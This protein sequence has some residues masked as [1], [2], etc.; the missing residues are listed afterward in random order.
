MLRLPLILWILF[1]GLSFYSTAQTYDFQRITQE[2]GLPSS[3]ITCMTQDSRNLLWIG[4]DG[5]GLVRFD[6]M[7]YTTFDEPNLFDNRFI[8]DIKEDS[9][10]NLVLCTRYN[11]VS[12][13]DGNRFFKSF[14]PRNSALRSESIW[15]SIPDEGGSYFFGD[16]EIF[17]IDL[18][19]KLTVLARNK[20]GYGVI[21]SVVKCAH[22]KFIFT[23][24][25]G[26]FEL[27]D[28]KVKPLS[29]FDNSYHTLIRKETNAILVGNDAGLVWLYN[30]RSNTKQ[31][32]IQIGTDQPFHI[33][34]M[35]LSRSGNLWLSGKDR[36][37]LL[38]WNDGTQTRFNASNGFTG[39]NVT[40]FYQDEVR[41]LYLGSLGTG[42]FRTGPQ[43]FFNYNNVQGLE[44]PNIFGV[45]STENAVYVGYNQDDAR[46]FTIESNGQ[47]LL[48]RV[49]EGNK[50]TNYFF[51][52]RSKN[53][54]FCS[55]QGVF[56]ETSAGLQ[57][58]TSLKN[59]HVVQA[60]ETDA[61][62]L[63]GTYGKGLLITDK[64]FNIIDIL[65]SNKNPYLPDYVYS[66]HQINA[67]NF[68]ISSNGSLIRISLKNG[69][70][71]FT[72]KLIDDV[73]SI[74]TEDSYGN[75]WY[76]GTNTLYSVSKKGKV[77]KFTKEQHGITSLLAYT[78]IGDNQGNIW[79]GSNRGV[80]KIQVRPNGTILTIKNYNS[81]N[82]FHGLETNIRAQYKDYEGNIY[83][84]TANGLVKC[85][86]AYNAPSWV[87]P[88]IVIS[89]VSVLN[90]TINWKPLN[91]E[92][93]WFN[94][95]KSKHIFK[96]TENQLTFEFTTVNAG[97]TDQFYYSYKL[98]GLDKN[99][100]EPST[101]QTVTYSNLRPGSYRFIVR[102]VDKN[103]V[104]FKTS[105]PLPF[106]ID[107]PFYASW[108]FISLT[109]VIAALLIYILIRQSITYNKEFVKESASSRD[110]KI[111]QLRIYLL[112]LGIL[113]P[114]SELVIEL[115]SIRTSSELLINLILGFMSLF[116][117]V[118][119]RKRNIF[120]RYL[121][122]MI[123]SVYLLYL[124]ISWYK[125]IALPFEFITIA[126]YFF[127]VFLGHIL[128]LNAKHYFVFLG[129]LALFLISI[130]FTPHLEV[131][132]SIIVTYI[133][134]FI[135]IIV[136]IKN[137]INNNLRERVILA[138][139]IVNNGQSI[140]ITANKAGEISFVSENVKELLGYS[141]H[142]LLGNQWWEKTIDDKVEFEN[143]KQELIEKLK[144]QEIT[145]RLVKTKSGA[146]KWIQWHD[147]E[148]SKNLIVGVGQDVT[149]LKKLEIEKEERQEQLRI[150]ALELEEY[151][152]K[153]EFENTLKERLMQSNS[154]QDVAQ[155]ALT[156]IASKLEN[157]VYIGIM[158][159]DKYENRV[160]GHRIFE[161]EI[162]STELYVSDLTSYA[163][164]KNGEIYVQDDLLSIPQPS[165]ND[166]Q[167]I[168]DGIGSYIAIPIRF[169]DEF[170]GILFVGFTQKMNLNNKE[171][172]MLIDATDI[173]AISAN[174]LRLQSL[175]KN[176]NDD[177][178]ASIN[179]ARTIQEALFPDIRSFSSRL[180]QVSLFFKP[181]DLVSGDFYWAKEINDYSFIALGD[182]TGHGVPGAFLTLL[183]INFLEQIVVVEGLKDPA[184]ILSRL[185]QQL[186]EALNRN[187]TDTLLRDGMEISICVIDHKNNTLLHAGAGLGLLYF[188]GEE[189]CHL[190]GQRLSIG[191]FRH[192]EQFVNNE[193]SFD[194]TYS[195]FMATD[196]YQDQ[197]GGLRNKRYSKNKLINLLREVKDEL[198]TEIEQ[199]LAHELQT[200]QGS[201]FQIDDITVIQF[202]INIP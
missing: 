40:F 38:L 17:Y 18:N 129:T 22:S 111:E 79:L 172:S 110:S 192:D 103:N 118:A 54:L 23:S 101:N 68:Y 95:P 65:D 39:S 67:S 121:Y 182:C 64:N 66:I 76:I 160:S 199:K 149:D 134:I 168:K 52:T 21:N 35:F 58:I 48:A 138:D 193:I 187:N 164:C 37:G 145:T 143:N 154:I 183:G 122:E 141:P 188:K 87:S 6:G 69:A 196:G 130:Y 174:R 12:F 165:Q 59:Y 142:E 173:V 100:S 89:S 51:K 184:A 167:N 44:G 81:K 153:L 50:G 139:K 25:K 195:F 19:Y 176:T 180:A 90:K 92:N 136:Q 94:V 26:V 49:F 194:D 123:V 57:A 2:Q 140:V 116:A 27:E 77:K 128:L 186:Y 150:Q 190:R 82:G 147:K 15:K 146:Y 124:I 1:T 31:P 191:D 83:M 72:K 46:K 97:F 119:T 109:I 127:F 36:E 144:T 43:L 13:F 162:Q 99:W 202:K 175:L 157:V 47:L 179:Y 161:G 151:A 185:D 16:Q 80:D 166:L 85:M 120:R 91:S 98:E 7:T 158:F 137:I 102:I 117:Y 189:E 93:K 84:G 5:A 135:V 132:Q 113:A 74:G 56:K 34:H 3:S 171:L 96:P 197:L 198:P 29:L 60:Y 201:H 108:W 9:K 88:D 105:D 107:T 114:A 41:N 156:H 4:T 14:H 10:G 200:Y 133:T 148:F 33:R 152:K 20:A 78:L 63:L 53:V 32:F 75:Y 112:F 61:H 30:E 181:K 8:T 131:N 170:L 24:E 73:L 42:L 106:V 71:Y 155:N 86:S 126:E 115:F 178:L 163:A 11:G 177:L 45:L 55:S 104:A 70:Y 62:F 169:Y 28:K 125:I 159:P